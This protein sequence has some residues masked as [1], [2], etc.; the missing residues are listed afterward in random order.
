Q[1]GVKVNYQAIGSGG[2]VRQISAKTVDFGASDK[3]LKDSKLAEIGSPIIH[4]PTCLGAVVVTYNLPGNPSLK[5]D[6]NVTSDIF[7]GKIT[8]WS[9]SK[10]AALNPSVSLPNKKITVVHR[11]DGSG[12]TYIFT[13]FLSKVNSA[14]KNGVGSGKSVKWPTGMG[15]KGNDGVAGNVKR[16]PGTIG[17]CELAYSIENKMPQAQ[18]KNMSGNFIKPE[19]KSIS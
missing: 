12:T 13:D 11:S 14:W 19:G 2:G 9:D 10:I 6:G 7:M 15:A 17:Y 8:N 4:V 5:L 3:F 16:T 18:I 1:F